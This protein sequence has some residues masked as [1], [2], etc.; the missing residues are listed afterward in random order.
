VA[1]VPAVPV[2]P[3]PPAPAVFVPAPAAPVPATPS[4][5]APVPPPPP[6][7]E[8]K[9]APVALLPE[10]AT[11]PPLPAVSAPIAPAA[12][13]P[14]RAVAAP[15]PAPEA[16]RP[17]EATLVDEQLPESLDRWLTQIENQP[18]PRAVDLDWRQ[19]W[20]AT[21]AVAT[22]APER[23]SGVRV[24]I[25]APSP[26]TRPAKVEL[27][28][29][30]W[31]RFAWAA[32]AL[33]VLVTAIVAGPAGVAASRSAWSRLQDR[34]TAPM[35]PLPPPPELKLAPPLTLPQLPEP[36]PIVAR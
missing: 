12:A 32:L 7:P 10:F 4:A 24:R 22:P 5:S 19:R 26:Y 1:F 15:E 23:R 11:P 27:G 18:Q 30:R 28:G 35:P 25:P 13:A 34:F 9:P 16:P 33:L 20:H 14:A 8:A 29:P 17:S 31:A 2:A 21:N 3:A 36:D 6:D